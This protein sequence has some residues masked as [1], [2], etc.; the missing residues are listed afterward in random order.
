MA[1]KNSQNMKEIFHDI[2]E[3]IENNYNVAISCN[4]Y[5]KEVLPKASSF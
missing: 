1:F 4:Y 5:P 3:V 2:P